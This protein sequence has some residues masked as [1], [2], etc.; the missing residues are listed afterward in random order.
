MRAGAV[1]RPGVR[2]LVVAGTAL[3][4]LV[5]LASVG[6]GDNLVYYRTPAELAATPTSA[7]ERVRLGGLVV[8]G[9]VTRRS[10]GVAFVLTDGTAD[11][12]VVHRGDPQGVFAEG[13]GA[14]V[15]GVLAAD[16]TFRSDL[17]MVKH[18]NEYRPPD[19]D[20]DGR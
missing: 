4:A 5:T 12:A 15:E 8:E 3:A 16:G 20:G 17:L 10:D 7:G 6:L 1:S 14:I 2:L 19:D 11:V 9:S 18:S 13:Q